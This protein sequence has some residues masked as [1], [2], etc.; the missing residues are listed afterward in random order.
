MYLVQPWFF[1]IVPD[2]VV[3]GTGSRA[4]LSERAAKFLAEAIFASV[5]NRSILSHGKASVADKAA[6]G[7]FVRVLGIAFI[8]WDHGVTL[9]NVPY[10][11]VDILCVVA[12]VTQKCT[13]PERQNSVGG[14]EY[15]LHDGGIRHVGGSGRFIERQT[16]DAV[17]Q[18]M[19]FVSP[20]KLVTAF[21]MLVGSGMD[22]Q[23]A[24][25]VGFGLI[26]RLEL[27][28]DKGLRIVLLCAGC[29]RRRVQADER[30]VHNAKLI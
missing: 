19:I 30:G 15:L 13:L 8:Q 18:H 27:V 7:Q 5:K 9:I 2:F 6:R 28:F 4:G 26:L 3:T 1:S 23:G 25:R 11:I 10:Q 17:H 22:V 24:V 14:S 12:F 20:V 29:N 16:G 21:V